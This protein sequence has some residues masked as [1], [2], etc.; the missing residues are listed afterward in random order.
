MQGKESEGFA[1]GKKAWFWLQFLVVIASGCR[2]VS[3]QACLKEPRIDVNFSRG[4]QGC[5]GV[6]LGREQGCP[7]EIPEVARCLAT[8]GGGMRQPQ[9]GHGLVWCWFD[10]ASLEG[11]YPLDVH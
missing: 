10:S 2:H 1:L 4:C 3:C 6:F 9:G 8:G 11:L 7:H 5:P